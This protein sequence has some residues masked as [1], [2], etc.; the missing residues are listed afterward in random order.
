[1]SDSSESSGWEN[2][3]PQSNQAEAQRQQQEREAQEII[4]QN[5][6]HNRQQAEIENAKKILGTPDSQSSSS[7]GWF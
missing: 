3:T 5:H 6:E 1:M 2:V 7:S 4:R